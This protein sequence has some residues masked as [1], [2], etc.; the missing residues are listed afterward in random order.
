[1]ATEI[2]VDVYGCR[3]HLRR[4]GAG[5]PLLFLH[6]AQGLQGWEPALAALARDFDVIAPDLPGFGRSEL[7]ERSE[8]VGDLALF[9]LDLLKV[10]G[11]ST[12]HVVGHCLGGWVALEMAIRCTRP[13]R[14]LTLAAS[15][16]LRLAGVPRADMFLHPEQSLAELL[17]AGESGA[18]WIGAWHATPEREDVYERNRAAAARFTWQPRLCNPKLSR[19]LHRIDVPTHILWGAQDKVLPP[20]Y[21]RALQERIAGAALTLLPDCGHLPHVEAPEA[22]AAHVRGFLERAA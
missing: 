3:L 16:G 7:G 5:A 1:M 13:M 4:D 11:L 9:H 10:L 22:F 6:G 2:E 15:A 18:A 12:V 17:F 20:A 19:W 14:T 8:D 21:G